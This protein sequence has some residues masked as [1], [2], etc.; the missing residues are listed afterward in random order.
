MKRGRLAPAMR[1]VQRIAV[2]A[3]F[4]PAIETSHESSTRS[5]RMR[6]LTWPSL[7]LVLAGCAGTMNPDAVRQ[8]RVVNDP[9]AMLRIADATRDGG[10]NAGAMAFYRRA[11]DLNPASSRA[12]LGLARALAE[13]GRTDDAI[14]ALRAAHA[15]LPTDADITGALGRLLVADHRPAEALVVFGEGIRSTPR[16]TP[17][18]I[19]QGVALDTLSRHKEAQASYAEAL[20][21]DPASIPAHKDLQLSQAASTPNPPAPAQPAPR[22]PSLLR[23][24]SSMAE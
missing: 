12:Q 18:L 16:S 10:D 23:L 8:A 13:Q 5:H 6:W 15:R 24:R 1:K 17:L 19:G 14:A 3:T 21:I 22:K 2:D 4:R 7:A 11:A 20:Q 9:A